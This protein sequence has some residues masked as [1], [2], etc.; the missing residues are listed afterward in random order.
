MYAQKEDRHFLFK[1]NLKRK[2]RLKLSMN[3]RVSKKVHVWAPISEPN[4]DYS[5]KC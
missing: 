3:L 1:A 2:S 5:C 4:F